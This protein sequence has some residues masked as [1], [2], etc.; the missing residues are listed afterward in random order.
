M[1]HSRLLEIINSRDAWAFVGSGP[2]SDAGLPDWG[3]LAQEAARHP[4]ATSLGRDELFNAAM[5]ARN[6]PKCF[7]FVEGKIGRNALEGILRDHLGAVTAPGELHNM[8]A[9]LPFKGYITTN[10][11]TLL[12]RA[13]GTSSGWVSVGNS[14]NECRK[15]SREADRVVWHVHGAIGMEAERSKLVVTQR[16]YDD[17]YLD[18]STM[19]L[20]QLR[21]LLAQRNV[22]IIGFGFGDLEVARLLRLIGRM[23][24][25]ARPIFAFLPKR[26]DF[27]TTA[28]RKMFLHSN[29]IEVIPYK[30]R[31]GGH[32]ALHDLLN[33]YSALSLRR[34]LNY[35]QTLRRV[36]SYDP[37]T[38]SLLVYNEL[39]LSRGA[40]LSTH[41]TEDLLRS[42]VLSKL[43]AHNELAHAEI[44]SDIRGLSIAIGRRV[45]GAKS[46]AEIDQD[47]Q[48]IVR[49]LRDDG[50]VN[51]A[52]ERVA[53]SPKGSEVVAT[54]SASARLLEEQFRSTLL[55]RAGSKAEPKTAVRLANAAEG[56][57]KDCIER[58]ALGVAMAMTLK[59]PAQLE[60]HM[61]A[62][63][64]GL[65][66]RLSELEDETEAS[67]LVN[68]VQDVLRHP[69]P[70]ERKFIGISLQ[71]K[72]GI[73]LLGFDHYTLAV[74]MENIAS[75]A[76]IIDSSTLIPYLA[77]SSPGH[78]AAVQL[79]RELERCGAPI[80]TTRML[81]DEVAEHAQWALDRAREG[82]GSF[83]SLPVFEAAT[84]RAGQRSNAFISGYASEL[85]QGT[86]NE[87]FVGYVGHACG[88]LR[89][90]VY[91][92]TPALRQTLEQHGVLT[93]DLA[94]ASDAD[95]VA[96]RQFEDYQSHLQRLREDAETFTRERQV[97]A[98]AEALVLVESVRSQSAPPALAD[99]TDAYFLSNTRIID[100][101]AQS[102]VAITMRPEAALQ[103][104]ATLRPGTPDD[105]AALTSGLLWELQE[106]GFDLV[107]KASLLRAYGPFLRATAE[108]RDAEVARMRK[109]EGEKYAGQ[110]FGSVA[111]LDLPVVVE[112]FAVQRVRQLEAELTEQR[113]HAKATAAL[114][115]EERTELERLRHKEAGRRRYVRRMGR[116]RGS[117]GKG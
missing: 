100:R 79:V 105:L 25:P 3:T 38:T 109:L 26:E 43:R 52:G 68:L 78:T 39:V 98:E 58:R 94:A 7:E 2:S 97:R 1:L 24:D 70:P 5:L 32:R 61:V 48:R 18:E 62:L 104:L 49:Q 65:Q 17:L 117:D 93:V 96:K 14:Y 13:L 19:P 88:R 114:S 90:G 63:L 20:R 89:K 29:N 91:C 33:V 37:E 83:E 112:S 59:E 21:G 77:R 86:A 54:H 74:R 57:I 34:S 67:K 110:E 111:P 73:H 116:K 51:V 99:A 80:L 106:R 31:K 60:Y 103:W 71:A 22:V 102:D 75:T 85:A 55:A 87:D 44:A 53:L 45:A 10:Y 66:I 28:G 36:P 69:E 82:G 108:L 16:D 81:V 15:V 95:E 42:Y 30:I 11:D 40:T 113:A 6:Y 47:V 41:V 107:D 76:F 84:G 12:E 9:D 64:Q 8:I 27:S 56:F 72:F 23:T 46:E 92:T 115:D 101:V 35:G 4:E 50:L